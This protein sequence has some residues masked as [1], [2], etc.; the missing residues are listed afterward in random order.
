MWKPKGEAYTRN[1]GPITA[2]M[3]R[4]WDYKNPAPDRYD[5]FLS[6]G[7]GILTVKMEELGVD[8]HDDK[9]DKIAQR[10]MTKLIKQ[11]IRSWAR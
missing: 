5:C 10:L 9:A 7:N 2:T 1:F 3:S 4:H 8:W 11:V 6:V